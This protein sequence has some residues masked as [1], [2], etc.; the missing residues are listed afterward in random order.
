LLLVLLL[1]LYVLLVTPWL[2]RS[3]PEDAVTASVL[4][5]PVVAMGAILTSFVSRTTPLRRTHLAFLGIAVVA[6][7]AAVSPLAFVQFGSYDLSLLVDL[8]WRY[9]QGQTPL[10]DYPVTLPAS[11]MA[12]TRGGL[13]FGATWGALTIVGAA[14]TATMAILTMLG[15]YV[16]G[17]RDV[18]VL[19]VAAIGVMI[20]WVGTTH[21]WHSAMAAQ[22]AAAGVAWALALARHRPIPVQIVTGMLL[23]LLLTSKQNVGWTVAAGILGVLLSQR[24]TRRTLGVVIPAAIATYV[25]INLVARTPIDYQL[26]VF[27]ALAAERERTPM[28]A[29][30]GTRDLIG[31]ILLLIPWVLI[32]LV[33]MTLA[34]WL[35]LGRRPRP[36]L[37][38]WACAA[39]AA[40]G[41]A[42]G[43]WTNWDAHWND[44]PL[45]L[46]VVGLLLYPIRPL[47]EPGPSVDPR[48]PPSAVLRTLVL[49]L[50][51]I[52]VP[53]AIG[54]GASRVRNRYVGPL[55][56][57]SELAPVESGFLAGVRMGPTGQAAVAAAQGVIQGPC[58]GGV[59]LGPRLEFLYAQWRLHSPIGLPLWWHP[60]SS[61][62]V[63]TDLPG[64]L[65]SLDSALPASFVTLGDDFT[66]L[67]EEMKSRLANTAV[68][69]EVGPL[70]TRCLTATAVG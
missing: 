10:E 4:A 63:G 49:L 41:W 8:A 58:D 11:F 57:E 22:A 32:P 9:K 67:P 70:R 36:E 29:P 33:L 42:A 16:G 12:V 60:G 37:Y 7:V 31:T 59:I 40:S 3:S 48:H 53:V 28:V 26:R 24:R 65:G 52:L 5:A 62:S 2:P 25:V 61:Y 43:V 17:A 34:A 19:V 54:E 21:L 30:P 46:L 6:A 18:R 39:V 27:G 13:L 45:A 15:L 44:A 68:A 51:A 23:G 35:A 69:G 38:V 55:F 1:L 66:R 50:C 56:E 14:F 20:P 47:S 64:I